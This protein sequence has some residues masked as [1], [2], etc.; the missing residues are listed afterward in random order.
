[1]CV[2]EIKLHVE[3][4]NTNSS[5]INS[6]PAINFNNEIY[7]KIKSVFKE[8]EIEEVYIDIELS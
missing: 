8:N 5:N 7:H 1:M 4:E 3:W 2:A 6:S